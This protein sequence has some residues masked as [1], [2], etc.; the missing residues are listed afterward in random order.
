MCSIA[1]F[2]CYGEA[3]PHPDILKGL[4]AACQTRG[5]NAAGMAYMNAN[6]QIMVRKQK[7]PAKVLVDGMSA[8]DWLE[9]ARSP[10]ALFHARA[11][12]KGTEDDN[13]NNHPVVHGGWVVVH[14]G[15]LTNDDELFEYYETERYAAVDT[16]AVP[17][18]LAQGKDYD[19]SLRQLSVLSGAASLAI[20][21]VATPDRI[22]IA[23][24]GG[25]DV[26]FFLDPQHQIM[27][28]CSTP[29]AGRV[30]PGYRVKNLGFFTISKL[31][32]NK[33]VVLE[34]DIDKT[35]LLKIERRPFFPVRSRIPAVWQSG[36][37]ESGAPPKTSTIGADPD[38][39]LHPLDRIGFVSR[40]E[41][42]TRG[43]DKRPFIWGQP[44]HAL[45]PKPD[46]DLSQVQPSW[47]NWDTIR[48]KFNVW[49]D[50]NGAGHLTQTYLTPYGRWMFDCL[51]I[52]MTGN[53]TATF[54]PA[55][56]I[57]KYWRRHFCEA[58]PD[59]KLPTE[60]G[61]LD[62]IFTLEEFSFV[63]GTRESP[64]GKIYV[65]GFMCPWC[66]I[67]ETTHAW[68]KLDFRCPVCC[69]QSKPFV[70]K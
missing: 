60:T 52:P 51:G 46:I 64:P 70:S 37:G 50:A 25:N 55:K 17:L 33:I 44:N 39:K 47:F 11:T 22:A 4:M 18:V 67:T 61:K 9:V 10:R 69:V 8:D 36:T 56:R 19:D 30:I 59:L 13:E 45:K 23:R 57:K 29:L 48:N 32:E 3:R 16:A 65:L 49:R 43:T 2:Y 40:H 7:G 35:R 24:L 38:P 62:G 42:K 26:Y 53:I 12:T 15:H 63:E 27:Y 41:N 21:S 31:H 1:G 6:A 66:G 14:N 58:I 54:F 28:W 34:P 5:S 68:S 20:W